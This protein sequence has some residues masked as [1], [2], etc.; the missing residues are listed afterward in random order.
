MARFLLQPVL[1]VHAQPYLS[2]W[3]IPRVEPRDVVHALTGG[4]GG[5]CWPRR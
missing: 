1:Y 3:C 5:R 2:L 4:S